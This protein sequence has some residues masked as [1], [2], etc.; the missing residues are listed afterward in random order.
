MSRIRSFGLVL[1]LLTGLALSAV[2]A[3]TARADHADNLDAASIQE[4][5]DYAAANGVTITEEDLFQENPEPSGSGGNSI[6]TERHYSSLVDGMLLGDPKADSSELFGPLP[7]WGWVR[8]C[9]VGT[10]FSDF[11]WH[12]TVKFCAITCSGSPKF[13]NR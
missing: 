5:I 1:G 3:T 11:I 10:Y 2:L 8:G 12:H 9:R 4:L 7:E 6:V 13:K